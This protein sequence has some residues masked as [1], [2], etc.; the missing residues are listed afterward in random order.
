MCGGDGLRG[1]Y[2]EF[3]EYTHRG[4]DGIGDVNGHHGDEHGPGAGTGVEV[5]EGSQ[6]GNRDGVGDLL[7][8]TVDGH[9]MM[10]TG[11]RTGTEART[12]AEMGTGR[13]TRK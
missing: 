5:N 8:C 11:T 12:V 9:R 4:R 2:V 7:Y 10:G 1:Y 3:D 13:G 6:D